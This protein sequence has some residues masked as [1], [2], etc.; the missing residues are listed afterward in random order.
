MT[1]QEKISRLAC[2]AMDVPSFPP[3]NPNPVIAGPPFAIRKTLLCA[4]CHAASVPVPLFPRVAFYQEAR[5]LFG[6]RKAGT[7]HR[8]SRPR[9]CPSLASASCCLLASLSALYFTSPRG[10]ETLVRVA[11][12]VIQARSDA[13]TMVANA[14]PDG[15]E[16]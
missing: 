15:L 9:S 13:G 8:R 4:E 7:N 3:A 6:D 5:V 11:R 1:D 16:P 14:A 12:T 2:A 10:E